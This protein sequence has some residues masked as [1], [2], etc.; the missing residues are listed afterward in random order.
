MLPGAGRIGML[1]DVAAAVHPRPL[2]IPHAEYAV[3]LGAG[4]KVDLLRSPKRRGG[5]ILIDARLEYHLVFRQ[6]ELCFPQGLIK[7]AEGRTAVAAD[8]AGGIEP[9]QRVA[10]VLQ[11]QQSNQGLGA[12]EECPARGESVFVLEGDAAQGG[13]HCGGRILP[14]F[15]MLSG[16]MARFMVRIRSIATS[17]CSSAM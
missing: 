13:V 7:A 17:P 9:G 8:I 5:E 15:R 4:G 3:V 2:A 12:G 10:L 16:S 1:E 6:V 14:G 11:Q